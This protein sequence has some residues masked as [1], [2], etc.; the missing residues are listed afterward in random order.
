VPAE[1]ATDGADDADG[2]V[3]EAGRA[4]DEDPGVDEEELELLEQAAIVVTNTRPSAGTRYTRRAVELDRIIT[5]PFGS[6]SC[7]Q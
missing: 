4:E 1:G 6:A 2:L 7:E 3:D 5:R